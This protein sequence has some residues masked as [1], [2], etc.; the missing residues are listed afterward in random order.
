M[1][2]NLLVKLQEAGFLVIGYADDVAIVAR[3]NFLTTLKERMDVALR[4]VQDWCLA[5][6]LTVNP[7]KTSAMIFTR[8]YKPDS[9]EPL[10]LWNKE[11]VYTSTVK[12]L[13]VTI[14]PK[15]S[16][17]YHLEVKR[18]QFYTS[19]WACRRA[20]GLTWGIKPK[21]ALWIYRA[22]LLPKFTY[23]SVIW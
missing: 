23:A 13:G 16:W 17:K 3:G 21:V 1:V 19:L 6:G 2:N 22:I 14:D 8:K 20:M 15:L 12:Y 7:S 9:I 11:L 5:K 18:K 10:M 4:I